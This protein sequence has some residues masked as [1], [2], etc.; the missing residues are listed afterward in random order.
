MKFTIINTQFFKEWRS[1]DLR[2][3]LDIASKDFYRY[4]VQQFNGRC[5]DDVQGCHTLREAKKAVTWIAED[6][7]LEANLIH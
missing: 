2:I 7:T 1:D 3:L 5:W 6:H 4:K